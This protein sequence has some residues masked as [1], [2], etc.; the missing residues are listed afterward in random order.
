MC[1]EQGSGKGSGEST[2]RRRQQRDKQGQ[3]KARDHAEHFVHPE[4]SG[5]L[6]KDFKQFG[7]IKDFARQ[8]SLRR[9]RVNSISNNITET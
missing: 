1:L 5:E 7:N 9:H 6:E 4:G 2:G 3:E 8:S